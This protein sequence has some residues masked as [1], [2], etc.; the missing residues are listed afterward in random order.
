[1][2]KVISILLV[3]VIT[4]GAFT[5][6][7][8]TA[9]AEENAP[10]VDVPSGYELFEF[11]KLYKDEKIEFNM[12][13]SKATVANDEKNG[14]VILSGKPAEIEKISV[15]L[16]D[17]LDLGDYTAGRVVVNALREVRYPC[18]AEVTLDDTD[19]F[20]IP[21]AQQKKAGVWTGEKNR[22]ADVSSL[23]LSGKH[24]AKFSFKFKD[25]VADKKTNVMLKNMLFVA[26][27][28]PVVDVDIDESL[29]TIDAMNGDLNHQTECYGNMTINIPE[30]YK[31]E[32]T[33]EALTSQ[34]Y[35]MEY[36]RGRGNSTWGNDK[37]PYKV[38]L[39]KKAS[40]L[41]MGENKHW[42]LIANYYDYSLL[43]NKYTYWLGKKLNMEFT[44]KCVFVD[45]VMNGSYLG[46]YCLSELVRLDK[47]RVELDELDES[48]TSGDELTGGYLLNCDSEPKDSFF[49]V[50]YG[51]EESVSYS[52][53]SPDF[54]ETM[55]PE[56][57]EYIKNY[58]Q[59]IYDAVYSDD[60]RDKDGVLYSEYLDVD[61]MIDYYIIQGTSDNGDAFGNG[62]TY[63]YK[64]RGGKLYWGPLWDF[65]YV[66]W[67]ATDFMDA[68]PYDVFRYDNF[69]MF[70]R[71]Y[72]KDSEFKEKFDK[73]VKEIDDLIAQ[74][75]EDGGQ[76]DIYAKDVYLSQYAN[77]QIIPSIYTEEVL[78]EPIEAE[79]TIPQIT[80]D[81]EIAR[82]KSWLK[83]RA[84]AQNEKIGSFIN[85]KRVANFY[86]DDELFFEYE[87]SDWNDEEIELDTPQAEGKE[88]LYWYTFNEDGEVKL[89]DFYPDDDA[90]EISFYAKWKN[91][92][93]YDIPELNKTNLSLKAG[94]A[95][96]LSVKNGKA[97]KWFSS[98]TKVAQV[99]NGKVTALKKGSAKI[100]AIINDLIHL[101]CKVKV[102]TSPKLSKSSVT[103]RK[104]NTVKVKI[105]GKASTVKNVYTKTKYAKVVSKTTA[106]TIKVKGL[107][108][109][110]TTLKIKVNGV[111][112]KLKVKVK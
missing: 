33:D 73:R 97:Q 94:A 50:N 60:L 59:N 22:C 48:V 71:L 91:E 3:I 55:V 57:L 49:T 82:F 38:K 61:S 8:V 101:V 64:K 63:L 76:I 39:K 25:G 1:M 107:K 106:K 13:D 52:V 45:V 65:D 67:A 103:V 37:K 109:G 90:Y 17:E 43:R 112:L 23:K 75:T 99:K 111:A 12:N 87:F 20:S 70:E 77:H 110:K 47:N 9:S 4:V 68:E 15:S 88:F 81:S 58:V 89:E 40:L 11:G 29:G 56:Q 32:Y 16:K 102:T 35:E 105:T 84:A 31:A 30:G 34:T 96:T 14:G 80:Y 69:P 74:T 95:Y 44:P 62:S 51:D 41:G 10:L 24:T 92:E 19:T 78:A 46:S 104:G 66:A 26:Y 83:N 18:T 93:N 108:K 79:V 21:A 85:G 98:N 28:V 54:D 7:P 53:E 72:S 100:Y 86:V 36:I 2:K 27:S 42:G 6:V 5:V